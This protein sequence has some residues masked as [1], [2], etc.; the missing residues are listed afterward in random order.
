[1]KQYGG[2]VAA[3]KIIYEPW[4]EYTELAR[5]DKVEGVVTVG[6]V[7]DE[8][9]MA[10]QVTLLRGLGDGLDENALAT[11]KKYQFKPGI[12]NG[13]PVA[14][15]INVEVKFQLADSPAQMQGPS[16]GSQGAVPVPVAPPRPPAPL[17]LIV[18]SAPDAPGGPVRVSAGTA[19][20]MVLTKV[21]PVYP[22]IAKAA[23]VQGPVILHAIISKDGT[24]ESLSVISG[25]GMLVDAARDA[26]SKWTYKPYLLNGQPT[27][28][29]TS[30]TE[31]F[32][33]EDSVAQGAM[34]QT[35]FTQAE[36][37][38]KELL[39]LEG[40]AQGAANRA[41]LAQAEQQYRELLALQPN[42]PNIRSID[43][44]GL[45]SVTPQEVAERFSR[46]GVGLTLETPFDEARVLRASAELKQLLWDHGRPNAT[47]I[48]TTKTIPPG[49]ISILF[50]VKEGPKGATQTPI[51]AG[52]AIDGVKQIGG[53]VKGPVVI[54]QPEPEYTAEAKQAK[55]MGVVT[56]S[57]I[58]DKNGIPQNVHV[59]RGVGMGL[60]DKAVEAV[61]QYKFKPAVE[62]GKPVAVFMNVE[63]NFEIF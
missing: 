30:I 25:N 20:G 49:V 44:K 18:P 9:G 38:Y 48:V 19:S 32:S 34:N 13:K 17:R 12:D 61:K 23:H 11:V 62:N 4:P 50:D 39:A 35:V 53:D 46:D 63:V 6:L 15:Y 1:M 40:T 56:V 22:A 8:Q 26:V 55:F 45:N 59:T 52:N 41:Q 7:V 10:Q 54:Y 5:R 33:L 47:V 60:D 57:I 51:P 37:R 31:N 21:D 36:K 2:D 29:E 43:Y 3:P 27:E 58:V 28:V 16:G 14:V 42:V 24:V